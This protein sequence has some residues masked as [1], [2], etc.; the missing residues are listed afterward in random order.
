MALTDRQ[1]LALPKVHLHCHLEGTLRAPTFVELARRDGVSLRY[2][3][4]AGENAA[5]ADADTGV[6]PED[7]YRFATFQEFLFTFAAVSR[8]LSRTDDYARLAREFVE[9]ARTQNVLYG[10]LFIS[11][12]V[13]RFFHPELDVR[14]AVTAIVGELRAA[15]AEYKLI[16][17]LTR[18]FGIDK[19]METS[20]LAVSLIDLDVIGVGLGGDEARF[21]P[22]LFCDAFAYA[23]SYGLHCVAHAGEAGDASSVRGAVEALGAERIGH[24]VRAI[25][26][27][28]VVDLLVERGVAL[29]IC[30]TSNFLTGAAER[31]RPHPFLELDRAGV[32]I[33]IDADDPA[34]FETSI[35]AEYGYVLEQA[36]PDTLERFVI[37]AAGA[38]FLSPERKREL[39]GRVGAE[40]AAGRRTVERN[41]GT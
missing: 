11:P 22:E 2:H 3:P 17:D 33:A 31:G 36:G 32:A 20:E 25:D 8:S 9:D 39:L 16:V 15:E 23:R 35:S 19:A 34:L 5:F 6:S 38:T 28:A 41:V 21:P 26:D 7:P 30:P 10:E 4:H 37:N 1:L 24:G 13:W 12:S 40:L 29:E 14:E 18:N 27:P